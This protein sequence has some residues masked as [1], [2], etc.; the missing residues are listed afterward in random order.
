[1]IAAAD[2]LGD[3]PDL[4]TLAAGDACGT[5]AAAASHRAR[6]RCRHP[7][8]RLLC[9]RQDHNISIPVLMSG[10]LNH[11]R[12][13]EPRPDGRNNASRGKNGAASKMYVSRLNME[14]SPQLLVGKDPNLRWE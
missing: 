13:R 9:G 3:L 8:R 5:R 14:R 4:P 10:R 11:M 2:P 6:A 7:H 1:M 12:C